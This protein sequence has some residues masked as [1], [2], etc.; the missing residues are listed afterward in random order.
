MQFPQ[1]NTGDDLDLPTSANNIVESLGS[2]H[3]ISQISSSHK[4]V[5]IGKPPSGTSNM[6]SCPEVLQ[7]VPSQTLSH[8][9]M[10]DDSLLLQPA[11]TSEEQVW[12]EGNSSMSEVVLPDDLLVQEP[13]LTTEKPPWE[14]LSI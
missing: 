8:F 6:E 2:H 9:L 14:V 1:L 3:L 11:L 10:M 4:N 13:M 12:E 5:D 7:E